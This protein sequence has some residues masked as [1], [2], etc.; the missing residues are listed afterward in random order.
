VNDSHPDFAVEIA[1]SR[2]TRSLRFHNRQGDYFTASIEGDGPQAAKL[3]WGYTDCEFLVQLFESI[4]LDWRGWQGER[5]WESIEGDLGLAVSSK[6]TG[7][8]TITITLCSNDGEDNWRLQVPIYSEG[9][10]LERIAHQVAAFF[11]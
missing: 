9:G 10:Q 11:R 4:A 8:I 7:Q 5:T 6:S 2:G 1:S 3:V